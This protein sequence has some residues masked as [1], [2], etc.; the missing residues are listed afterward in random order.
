MTKR[1]F[2]GSLLESAGRS[3]RRISDWLGKCFLSV[4]YVFFGGV[5]D[6]LYWMKGCVGNK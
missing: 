5:T 1:C 4:L 3:V 6:K 2:I